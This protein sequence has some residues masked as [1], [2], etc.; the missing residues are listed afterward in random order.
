LLAG[1]VALFVVVLAAFAALFWPF[2]LVVL[3]W[4]RTSPP[5]H[6]LNDPNWHARR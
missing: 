5:D 6:L 4:Q 2:T 1:G 3:A